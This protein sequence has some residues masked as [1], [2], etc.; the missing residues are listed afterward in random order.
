MQYK[1]DWSLRKD[2]PPLGA[3]DSQP[4]TK[5]DGT[6]AEALKLEAATVT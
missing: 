2:D 5:P 4:S 3:T 6:E 1:H